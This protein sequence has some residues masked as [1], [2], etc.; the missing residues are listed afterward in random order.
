M[1][2]PQGSSD[3]TAWPS[4]DD[5]ATENGTASASPNKPAPNDHVELRDMPG[6]EATVSDEDDLMQLARLG[7]VGRIQKLFDEGKFTPA[8]RDAEGITPLHVCCG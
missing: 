3:P 8:Y 5:A 1:S 7:D 6:A 2:T 4:H